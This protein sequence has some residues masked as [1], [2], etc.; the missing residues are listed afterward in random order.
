MST[1][2][3][4]RKLCQPSYIQ[5]Q[6]AHG[7]DRRDGRL[8]ISFT[9]PIVRFKLPEPGMY[10]GAVSQSGSKITFIVLIAAR[11]ARHTLKR[12]LKN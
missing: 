7:R 11:G 8:P 2:G 5:S 12:V 1:W 4:G 6:V 10:D 9:R 3:A